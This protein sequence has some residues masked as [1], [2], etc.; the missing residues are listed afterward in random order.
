MEEFHRQSDESLS[1]DGNGSAHW[2]ITCHHSH[3][4]GA[5]TKHTLVNARA[6]MDYALCSLAMHALTCLADDTSTESD[7]Y[8]Q[9]C[10]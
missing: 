7:I 4:E 6:F 9:T 8:L 5:A 2:E 3:R 1:P 10:V